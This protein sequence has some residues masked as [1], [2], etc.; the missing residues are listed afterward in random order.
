MPD[1][2]SNYQYNSQTGYLSWDSVTGSI[3]Y[4]IIFVPEAGDNWC[5]AYFGGDDTSV[6]FAQPAGRYKTKGKKKGT[7]GWGVWGDEEII[8]VT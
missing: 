2:P 8:I 4:E 1:A 5:I 3:E 7:G 6:E